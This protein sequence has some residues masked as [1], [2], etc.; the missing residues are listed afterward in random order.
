MG[1]LDQVKG[2][3]TGLTGKIPK[4]A[5]DLAKAQILA[6]QAKILSTVAP[7]ASDLGKKTLGFFS[8]TTGIIIIVVLI[9]VLIGLGVWLYYYLTPKSSPPPQLP[10]APA[11]PTPAA[12]SGT[13][14][15]A[16]LTPTAPVVPGRSDNSDEFDSSDNT[17]FTTDNSDFTF[18]EGF[19][20]PAVPAQSITAEEVTLVNLQPLAIKDAGFTGPYP[21]GKYDPETATAN[22]IKAGFRFLTLQIDYM[23]TSKNG[24]AAKNIPTLLVRGPDGALVSGNSGDIELV[25]KTIANFAFRPEAPNYERPI[26]LYLHINR[27]P[28]RVKNPGDYIRFLSKIAKALNPLAPS[29][30]GLTPLGNFTRQKLEGVLLTTPIHSFEGNT[31]ILSNAD[32]SMFRS[33]APSAE[34]YNPAEDLDFWVNMRVYLD[35]EEDTLGISTAAPSDIRVSAVVADLNRLLALPPAKKDTIAGKNKTRYSIALGSRLTN[36]TPADIDTSLNQLGLNAVPIDI[37]T[38][39]NAQVLKITEEYSHMPYRP[40]PAALRNV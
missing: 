37:F 22:A 29:H 12:P 39:S 11:L 23:D 38:P 30:L 35:S 8:S 26:I 18:S 9:L 40:K 21:S 24:Y 10:A 5:V 6:N 7:I 20:A 25:A 32:T 36:P 1:L 31:I 17:D 19:Q 28:N 13:S 27:A 34:R 4:G 3:I 16:A 15:S 14:G 33:K 2:K